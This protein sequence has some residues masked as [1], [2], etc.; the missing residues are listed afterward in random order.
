MIAKTGIEKFY[1][2]FNRYPKD[3][4]DVVSTGYLKSSSVCPNSYAELI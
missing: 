4:D 1:K 3:W 2:Y